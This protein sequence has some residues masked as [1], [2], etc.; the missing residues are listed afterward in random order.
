MGGFIAL[1]IVLALGV[2]IGWPIIREWPFLRKR[3]GV[4]PKPPTPSTGGA[5]GDWD[6]ED[7]EEEME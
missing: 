4:P 7:E 5:G 6:D 3:Y 1:L 2:Y